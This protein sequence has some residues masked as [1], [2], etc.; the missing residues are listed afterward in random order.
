MDRENV[1]K[2]DVQHGSFI[3]RIAWVNIVLQVLFPIA[4]SLTPVM[5]ASASRQ[6][7]NSPL[8][9]TEK[10]WLITTDSQN[11]S[12]K[13]EKQLANIARQTGEF[14]K[15]NPGT[16][17]A[18]EIARSTLVSKTN[19]EIERWFKQF[20]NARIQLNADK[21]FSLK[22]SQ[23]DLLFPLWEQKENLIFNQS[24]LHRTDGR[25]QANL[26]LGWRHFASDYMFG[27]NAFFDYDLSRRHSRIGLGVEYWRD[28]L[29]LN[30]NGYMRTS[31]WKD[32]PD[33]E[34]Y[35][36][37]ASNGWDIRAEGY[38]PQYPQLGAKLIYEQYYGNEVALFGK[39]N[40][41]KNPHAFTAGITYTP[42]P[43][44][45]IGAEQRQGKEGR[46]DTKLNLQINYQ[47]GVPWFK[48]ISTDAISQL[49][50]LSNNRY[51][52][53]E[54]NNNIVLE[55]Q[56]KQVIK[57][58]LD[59]V[60]EG[61]SGE[62]KP[63]KVAVTAKYGLERIDWDF[64]SLTANG[65]KI[66]EKG[67]NNYRILMPD[68]QYGKE[69]GNTYQ[70][71]AVAIDKKGNHSAR[72]YIQVI[73][74]SA[75]IDKIRSLFYPEKSELPADGKSTR[76]MTLEIK[77]QRNLPVDVDAK[78][79][80]IKV[81]SDRKT[82]NDQSTPVIVSRSKSTENSVEP[83]LF[84]GALAMEF[85][86]APMV[87]QARSKRA[88]STVTGP[89]AQ[90]SAFQ[91]V[92]VGKYIAI[93]TAGTRTEMLTI[94]PSARNIIFSSANIVVKANEKTAQIKS[95]QLSVLQN[96]ASADGNAL[97]KIRLTVT[98]KFGNP[99]PDYIVKS[100]ANNGA[101]I[102]E[103]G[104]T[105]MN[106]QLVISVTN[107]NAGTTTI[108]VNLG[109]KK[110]SVDVIFIPD[111]KTAHI[112]EGN[113]QIIH[114]DGSI[115]GKGDIFVADGQTKYLIKAIV[116]D[117]SGN[118]IPDVEMIFQADNQAYITSERVKTNKQGVAET[119]I[120]STKSGVTTIIAT[121]N[122]STGAVQTKVPMTFVGHKMTVSVLKV[123][124]DN[125]NNQPDPEGKYLA[126]GKTPVTVKAFVV[127]ENGNPLTSVTVYWDSDRDKSIVNLGSLQSDTD[128][129]GIAFTTVTS[130]QAFDVKVTAST[131][132]SS[133]RS[134][135]TSAPI[136]FKA[137][138][139]TGTLS[140]IKPE[141]PSNIIADGIDSVEL[142]TQVFDDNGNVLEGVEVTWTT[143]K[144]GAVVNQT[145]ITDENGIARTTLRST[146]S[147]EL[148]VT[149]T[150]G[151]GSD[152]VQSININAEA[153]WRTAKVRLIS[154]KKDA[155]ADRHDGIKVT[156]TVVDENNNPLSGKN[157]IWRSSE[158]DNQLKPV[159]GFIDKQG[160][161]STI[162]SGTKAGNTVVE[163]VFMDEVKANLTVTFTAIQPDFVN[164]D[165]VGMKKQSHFTLSP[166]SIIADGIARAEATLILKDQYGNLIPN[167]NN[168]I[169]YSVIAG[170]ASSI[171]FHDKKESAAGVYK[172][173]VSGTKEG[174]VDIRVGITGQLYFDES[175]GLVANGTT[176]QLASVTMIKGSANTPNNPPFI[177]AK[178]DG[179]DNVIIKAQ[180]QD[181]NGNT[182]LPNVVVGWKS[183]LGDLSSTLSKTDAN[184]V[185]EITLTSKQAGNAQVTA[186]LATGEKTAQ[187]QAKFIAGSLSTSHS[188][189]HISKNIA[190]AGEEI[191]VTFTPK[192]IYG[193][194]LIS[195]I[196]NIALEYSNDLGITP[197]PAIFQKNNSGDYF[198]NIQAKNVGHT[199]I[200]VNVDSLKI[201]QSVKLEI[202]ADNA[203]PRASDEQNPFVVNKKGVNGVLK[204]KDNVTVDETVIYS[205]KL[206]DENGNPL[207]KDIPTYWSV[208]GK[209]VLNRTN[210]LTDDKG[211]AKVELS[212][213]ETGEA[214]VT[215]NLLGGK[216]Y[217]RAMIFTAGKLDANRSEVTLST[218][219]VI[220]D[221]SD[222]TTLIVTLYDTSKNLIPNQSTAIKV[223][224][225]HNIN[226]PAK[227]T[228]DSARLGEYHIS[229]TGTKIG[230]A[231]LTVS[232]G[233][234]NLAKK[235]I[236]TFV[237]DGK[238]KRITAPVVNPSLI[239][240]GNLVTYSVKVI[241]VN[242][243]PLEGMMVS[244][245]LPS[246]MDYAE[247]DKPKSASQTNKQGIAELSIKPVRAGKFTVEASLDGSIH[248]DMPE[249]TVTP[250]AV[251]LQ[252]SFFVTDVRE[253]G[254]AG[255]QKE[256][257]LAVKLL[258]KYDNPI[259]G[260]MVE[261]RPSGN[262]NGFNVGPV[263][264]NGDGTYTASAISGVQGYED[265]KATVDGQQIG[266]TL[267]IK[268]GAITP[269]LRFDNKDVTAVY[270]KNYRHSQKVQNAPSGIRQ[271]WTSSAPDVA[272][273]DDTGKVALLKAGKTT[274][275][276][277]TGTNGQYNRADASY[278]L[279]VERA[280]P[281]LKS[282]DEQIV[283]VW[284]D[285]I[286]NEATPE[287]GNPDVVDSNLLKLIQFSSSNDNVVQVDKQGNLIPVKPGTA[288]I[289]IKVPETEQFKPSAVN[290]VYTLNKGRVDGMPF[291]PTVQDHLNGTVKLKQMVTLPQYA[292]G[293]WESGNESVIKILSNGD[294]KRKSAGLARMTYYI[295]G[296]DYYI[297][298]YKSYNIEL[299]DK[300]DMNFGAIQYSSKGSMTSTG[301]WKPVFTDDKIS[302]NWNIDHSN[303]YRPTYRV[304]VQLVDT[305]S[306]KTVDSKDYKVSSSTKFKR[307]LFDA[308]SEYY[309]KKLRIKLIATGFEQ[310]KEKKQSEEI[311]VTNRRPDEIW[312]SL[313]IKTMV[314]FR[315]FAVFQSNYW[316]NS[317]QETEAG[318]THHVMVMIAKN[319]EINFGEKELLSPMVLKYQAKNRRYKDTYFSY[320]N[321]DDKNASKKSVVDIITKTT[322]LGAQTDAPV[323]ARVAIINSECWKNHQEGYGM[324][325][326]IEY[327]GET[328]EYQGLGGDSKG[329]GY[330]GNGDGANILNTT[331]IWMM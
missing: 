62:E 295:D 278:Q 206:E 46:S 109:E 279:T 124:L 10:K 38:L 167:Q 258:D 79:I 37:R 330:G 292:K 31:N 215:V 137:D 76:E 235:P 248:Q 297:S 96:N 147:G 53:V 41:Q 12:N 268:V 155:V 1:N 250:S 312:A 122:S 102:Q 218:H 285:G 157:I 247:G 213:Q 197:N 185:A 83:S 207:G 223:T 72:A 165:A 100:S 128:E 328:Y 198:A 264:D 273:V 237:G 65:G 81:E 308:K 116:I 132:K 233:G 91:R 192:D 224:S 262:L 169:K 68:Y 217:S 322:S 287:F 6:E 142:S 133:E 57:L 212:S 74:S 178:A 32:S 48:Q 156:A 270:T 15:K 127:D 162:I 205:I 67:E 17:S 108:T 153:D 19:N 274:I 143:D 56:K 317:C 140:A 252:K 69:A 52:F 272:T 145:S 29:K 179:Q 186:V 4:G 261:I 309:G 86:Q 263:K 170:D 75:A 280:D 173:S 245:R 253:I 16:D 320:L 47:I 99:I 161:A 260:K 226:I 202:V 33:L 276:V 191:Q 27:N 163:A 98:D 9:P 305:Q 177:S 5:T 298:D 95:G 168:K 238:S 229:I 221:G 64:T 201:D 323:G 106:G 43:I 34:D 141:N 282:K 14:L 290:T 152:D 242:N 289:I 321:R 284:N 154:D 150:H 8:P 246:S 51:G 327:Q 138:I 288:T 78:E 329:Y 241:D 20:G 136:K 254:T 134:S 281:Q 39:D 22:N 319:S 216:S 49:R 63:L 42:V 126:D 244:W 60:I 25:T 195:A 92:D 225:P 158:K 294:W 187:T 77:D 23:F 117:K 315:A 259:M 172:V 304:N 111:E 220:A 101:D 313:T 200:V 94:T 114:P 55:Y 85:A 7:H 103:D 303:K 82:P 183:S 184:G 97:N 257:T 176:A 88:A 144:E 208:E 13:Q 131:N 93:V 90:V 204:G 190:V 149:V 275:T 21:N 283:A 331:T 180:L 112:I 231:E 129:N 211:T 314:K 159:A 30:V 120:S 146:K 59:E 300:P 110:Y 227:F 324:K 107:T 209:G 115:A 325:L 2:I 299:Y 50:K 36:E 71:S 316:D 89:S 240:A 164:A 228:E 160:N 58:Q 121:V 286:N 326:I 193:N 194:T 266:N 11:E 239:K 181:K 267:K 139:S 148:I 118:L 125:S 222:N 307:T 130:T 80:T 249:L 171:T 271:M 214:K 306:G 66:I 35:S 196:R 174:E 113:L 54:R 87:R 293:H 302:I 234:V 269:K 61:Y 210:V 44:I 123:E 28:Y 24:S 296:N 73:V 301:D 84:K 230:D 105:D 219:R 104:A 291:L 3:R 310:L 236:L 135:S 119:S 26:G 188:L 203:T 232:V 40:R 18:I 182:A 199:N 256:A 277:Q 166:Q 255:T 189:V 318:N 151:D 70:I 311:L 265:I 251:D 243:N 45:T 175:L